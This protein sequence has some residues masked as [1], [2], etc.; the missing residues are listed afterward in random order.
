MF[1][2][3]MVPVDL[4]QTESLKK[5]LTAA[6]DLSKHYQ[7]PIVYVSV[8]T[9]TPSEVAHSPEEFAAKLD[10]FAQAQAAVH[11]VAASAK[12]LVSHD[13]A[14]DLNDA[15]TKAIDEIGADLVVMSTH[16]PSLADLFGA[17]HGAGV[18]AHAAVSVFLVR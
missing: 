17:S 8:T 15:L 4:Q 1:T 13:P 12:A 7:A 2:K 10:A 16:L 5:A 3:I 11:G 6:A 18:A 9:S 14:V